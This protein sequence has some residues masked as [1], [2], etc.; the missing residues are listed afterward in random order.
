MKMKLS[1]NSD[2]DVSAKHFNIEMVG[3]FVALDMRGIGAG[4][5]LYDNLSDCFAAITNPDPAKNPMPARRQFE[6]LS[7]VKAYAAK[8]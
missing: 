5:L 4:W 2:A 1:I 6:T 8:I 3:N 7:Q